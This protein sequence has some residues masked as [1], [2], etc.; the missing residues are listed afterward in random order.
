MRLVIFERRAFVREG[1]RS[2]LARER[3]I[4]VL[5]AV[6]SDDELARLCAD[7]TPDLVLIGPDSATDLWMP[8]GAPGSRQPRFVRFSH[9]RRLA[10]EPGTVVAD[11]VGQLLA[12]L[13]AGEGHSRPSINRKPAPDASAVLTP[14]QI[15][16]LGCV[17][18]GLSAASIGERLGVSHRT[19]ENHLRAIYARLDVQ[20]GT[21]AVAVALRE[22]LLDPHTDT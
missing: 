12:A 20:S 1:L 5:G 8:T 7:S 14:R 9:D 4:E 16:V 15:E 3:D 17:R 21:H 2:L 19:I 10:Q 18:D 6:A 22:G 13:R 11:G